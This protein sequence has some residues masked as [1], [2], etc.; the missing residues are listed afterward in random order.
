[1]SYTP[2]TCVKADEIAVPLRLTTPFVDWTIYPITSPN[3]AFITRNNDLTFN[4]YG[5]YID[6]GTDQN[7][8]TNEPVR[9]EG[10]FGGFFTGSKFMAFT[11]IGTDW[12][13]GYTSQAY[14]D[15][16]N[17]SAPPLTSVNLGNAGMAPLAVTVTEPDWR[18]VPL[19]PSVLGGDRLCWLESRG[20]SFH[21]LTATTAALSRQQAFPVEAGETSRKLVQSITGMVFEDGDY[22]LLTDLGSSGSYYQDPPFSLIGTRFTPTTVGDPFDYEKFQITFDDEA[23]NTNLAESGIGGVTCAGSNF[24]IIIDDVT[25]FLEKRRIRVSK[26]FTSYTEYVF[27][28]NQAVQDMILSN[29]PDIVQGA[30]GEFCVIGYGYDGDDWP[31]G[32]YHLGGSC[33]PAGPTQGHVYSRKRTRVSRPNDHGFLIPSGDMDDGGDFLITSGDAGGGRFKWQRAQDDG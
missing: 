13:I 14:T 16:D 28:G 2:I 18:E 26:D 27:S 10:N 20:T 24:D 8:I 21:L 12:H 25:A 33:Q 4:T 19:G 7:F 32:T 17:T 11:R 31:I 30:N 22:W 9:D 15:P 5:S 23:L 3:F 29:F 1:M 6:N